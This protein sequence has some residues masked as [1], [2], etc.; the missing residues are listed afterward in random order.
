MGISMSQKKNKYYKYRSIYS[1]RSRREPHKFTQSIIQSRSLFYATPSSFNDPFDCNLKL[2]VNDSTDEEW[3]GYLDDMIAIN[4]KDGSK[5]SEVKNRR[6]WVSD[7]R[8]R[9]I[10]RDANRKHYE[11][12]SVLCLS[13]RPDSI[14]MFA[15]YGDD[16]YGVVI[17]LEFA[18]DE[19]PCGIPYGDPSERENLYDR[20]VVAHNVKYA[21][22]IP[23]L[24]YHRMYKTTQMVENILFTKF[25]GWKH[26]EEFRIFRRGVSA[27]A[28]QFPPAMLT[29]IIFGARTTGNDIALVKQWLAAHGDP[30]I[31]AK[32]EVSSVDFKLDIKDFET[33]RA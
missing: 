5:L 23:E 11:D 12:S 3:I 22:K 33:F 29:R 13:R 1:D 28:V 24:N 18:D 25:D 30:V 6:L 27:S 32:A 8:L 17:E 19:Y 10:G 16:H 4:P 9:D 21:S 26:E 14:P 7:P 31:L 2:H 20:K 15:Y